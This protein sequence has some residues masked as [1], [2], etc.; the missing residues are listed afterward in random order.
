MEGRHH[1][2]KKGAYVV[3]ANHASYL[4]IAMLTWVFHRF[5]AFVGKSSLGK[6]PLF[7]YYFRKAHISVNRKDG[8]DRAKA[9]EHSKAKVKQGRPVVFFPEGRITSENQPA[10]GPFRE[11]AF[12][13]AVDTGAPI[14]PVTICHNWYIL[15]DDGQFAAWW[16]IPRIVI[17]PPIETI[18]L[19]EADVKP[20]LQQT[21]DIISEG[22]RKHNE[23]YY[24]I[25][26]A[27]E[28]QQVKA[29]NI[30]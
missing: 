11:G 9:L 27:E 29:W 25:R 22:L 19:T 6:V 21:H 12:K 3:A 24:R 16:K 7:G 4:D 20:L 13:C 2:P 1:I 28:Q 5:I 14:L 8:N 30:Y 10:V 15:P 18:G 26:E 17:H 23:R